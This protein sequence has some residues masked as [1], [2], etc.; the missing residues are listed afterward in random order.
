MIGAVDKPGVYSFMGQ[1]TV[2]DALALAGGLMG[3]G[4][5]AAGQLLF[6]IRP[7]NFE[8]E[9]TK[10]ENQADD[11]KNPRTFL[12]DLENLLVKGDLKLNL[13]L[14]HGDIIN[15]PV[16]GKVFVAGEVRSP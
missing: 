12:V 8:E 15:V 16:S 11:K 4:D 10:E 7:P 14:Q 9:D 2:L 1:K 6:L 3:K 13:A 5:D